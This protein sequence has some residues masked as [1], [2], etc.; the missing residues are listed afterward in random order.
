[1][2][3][4]NTVAQ[5]N[6]AEYHAR[7]W[8]REAHKMFGDNIGTMPAIKMNARLTATGGRAFLD[9]NYCDFSC[10]L[11]DRE[12]DYFKA[13]TIPHELAHHI[14]WRL[15]KDNGHGAAWKNVALQLYGENNRCHAMGTKHRHQKAGK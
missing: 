6:F 5:Q 14:A 2:A 7:I 13:N 9:Q 1:M 15:Y 11:M 8:W 12:P 4:Y 10:Y 3:K